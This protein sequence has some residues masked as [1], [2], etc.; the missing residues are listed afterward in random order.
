MVSSEFTEYAMLCRDK[1]ACLLRADR[2]P[3]LLSLSS[4]RQG[5]IAV[6]MVAL[7]MVSEVPRGR[8]KLRKPYAADAPIAKNTLASKS[9]GYMFFACTNTTK[10]APMI[11]YP[12]VATHRTPSLS[13]MRPHAGHA[14]RATISSANPK[15]PTTSPMS[16]FW[17]RRSEI[18]K[19]TEL[20]R[21]TRKEM[22]N[23]ATPQRY[24]AACRRVVE[25]EKGTRRA[26]DAIVRLSD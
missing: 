25:D 15:V 6:T 17:P 3:S 12:I 14:T 19:L 9:C 26:K 13:E 16:C 22:E 24:V 11:R 8:L 7:S 4:V 2:P 21:K 5:S 18:T 20:L 10:D 1:R 23:S